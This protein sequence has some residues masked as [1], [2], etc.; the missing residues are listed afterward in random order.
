MKKQ[1][2]AA[3]LFFTIYSLQGQELTKEDYA[4]AVSFMYNNYSDKVYNLHTSVNWFEDESGLWFIE[5]SKEGKAYKTVNFK[6]KKVTNLFDHN[7]LANSLKDITNKEVKPHALSI[8]SA[9]PTAN[10]NMTIVSNGKKYALNLKSYELLEIEE[11]KEDNNPFESK[12]P[13]G[14]WIAFTKDYNLYIK[15]TD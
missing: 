13:D 15:S 12:S 9:E 7:K 8:S 10:G 3:L 14:K 4:R 1:L 6:N 5:F 11:E 2:L